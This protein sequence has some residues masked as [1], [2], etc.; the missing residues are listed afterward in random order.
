[1]EN[2]KKMIIII[3]VLLVFISVLLI[4]KKVFK[5]NNVVDNPN[6][7]PIVNPNIQNPN[8]EF[9]YKIIYETNN[10]VKNENYLISPLS[11]GYALSLL[12]EGSDGNTKTQ[13]D[14]LLNGYKLPNI[15]NVK[16]RIG[17]A[18]LLFIRNRYKNEINQNFISS[19]QNKYN[20]DLMFD[21]FVTPKKANDWISDKTYKMIPNA[22]DKLSEDFVL[23]VANTIAIDVE[24]RNK[25]ECHR[26]QKKE[27]TKIDNTKMDTPM[28]H[29]QDDVYYIEN[30]NAKG[31]IK[32]Y[33]I[34]DTKTNKEVYEENENT[35][36]LQY[37]AILPNTDITEYLKN[38]NSKELNNLLE[39]KKS[40]DS[41]TEISYSLPKYTYDY[42]YEDFQKMLNNLGMT[43]AFNGD[44]ANFKNMVND[45]SDLELFVSKSI[46][47]THIELSENGTKAAAVTAFIMDKNAAFMDPKDKI[48]IN[49][50]KPF[51]YIIKDKNSDNIWFFGTVYEPMEWEKNTDSCSYR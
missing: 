46:H 15:I 16:D 3:L 17:I 2:K 19:L 20:S 6:D 23:G 34:Y 10:L 51:I 25:F 32:D 45:Q 40:S 30:S 35:I 7:N 36:A 21:D 13:I 50:D 31:I 9:D 28:M 1:M 41:K 24:W 5:K 39:T 48:E 37:I 47:K 18:N 33:K 38:F 44:I 43:D 26:T 42:T 8:T 11:M 27:F 49:F 29:G 12:N 4:Y 22:I 14:S